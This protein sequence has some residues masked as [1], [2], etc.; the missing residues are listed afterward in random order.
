MLKELRSLVEFDDADVDAFR[1]RFARR[2]RLYESVPLKLV[3]SEQEIAALAVNRF[4]LPGVVIEAQLVRHYPM[5]SLMAHAIGSVRRISKPTCRRSI[6]CVTAQRSS[7]GNSASNAFMK[8]RCT[9]RSVTSKSK[10]S[11]RPDPEGAQ[12]AAAV[13]GGA[14]LTLQ[15]DTHLQTV[16]TRRSANGGAVVAIDPRTG[17]ILALVSNPGYDPN[18]F[19]TGISAHYKELRRSRDAAV[20]SRHERPIRTRF[21]VQTG[22]GA[23][24]I[25]HGATDWDR[26][27]IDHG[28]YRL[29]DRRVPRLEL[30]GRQQRRARCGRPDARHLPVANVYF[31]DLATHRYR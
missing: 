22:R 6:R 16:A 14:E 27:I 11:A 26:T 17:G 15:L 18:L 23:G 12:R 9:V 5:G 30:E 21:D 10:P 25:A 1:K 19:V 20:Q 29:P 7:S 2:Q 3:L 24:R 4:R 31:Y 28:T 8:V 13:A